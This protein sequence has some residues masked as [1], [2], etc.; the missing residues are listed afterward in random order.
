MHSDEGAT[1]SRPAW[2]TL[3][4]YVREGVLGEV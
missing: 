2:N 3:V 4:R 1:L